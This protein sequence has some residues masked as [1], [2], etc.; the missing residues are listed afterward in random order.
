MPLAAGPRRRTTWIILRARR[1][2]AGPGQ[3]IMVNRCSPT[4]TSNRPWSRGLR[5]Q[6]FAGH[7]D[8]L[9]VFIVDFKA[10]I[11][12]A[13]VWERSQIV[14]GKRFLVKRTGC[15]AGR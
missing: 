14:I 9:V 3:S 4:V 11:K 13:P 6:L 5:C 10:E 8:R 1:P 12:I 7:Q 2:A 15:R